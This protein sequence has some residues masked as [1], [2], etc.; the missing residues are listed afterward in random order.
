MTNFPA[1]LKV[2]LQ[3]CL[4]R[5]PRTYHLTLSVTF[6]VTSGQSRLA[7][8][9]TGT[10]QQP[11]QRPARPPGKAWILFDASCLH[12]IVQEKP[13]QRRLCWL[14]PCG[15]H[16]LRGTRRLF[17]TGGWCSSV[18]FRAAVSISELEAAI[19]TLPLGNKAFGFLWDTQNWMKL[20][21]LK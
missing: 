21:Q 16:K 5:G 14:F 13:S 2:F 19:Y 12:G 10:F 20:C 18:S 4:E 15:N 6:L 9:P 3:R 17:L 11:V 7:L 8:L 1:P